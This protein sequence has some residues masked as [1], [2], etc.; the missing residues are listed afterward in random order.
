[1]RCEMPTNPTLTVASASNKTYALGLAVA[2][3][4][5][6]RHASRRYHLKFEVLDGGIPDNDWRKLCQSL[7]KLHPSVECIRLQPRMADFEGLPQDWGASVMTY[8][9][10]ALPELSQAERILYVDADMVIQEDVA[11]IWERPMPEGCVVAASRDIIT[12]TLA[13]AKLPLADFN[14]NPAHHYLQAGFLM[15]D[16]NAWKR[17]RVSQRV[18]DYL[19]KYPNNAMHWDQSALNVVLYGRWDLLPDEWNTPAW[20]ADSGRGGTRVDAPLL[21][22]VGPNKPWIL[23]HTTGESAKRFYEVVD[24]T[25]YRKWRPSTWRQSLKQAKYRLHQTLSL[26]WLTNLLPKMG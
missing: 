23:G 17:E 4:S 1:M 20:W 9:R 6:A 13:K 15:I 14:M 25:E 26:K 16:M 2:L 21:H 3:A 10:L 18:L 24:Q 22:Y 8:A 12:G 19:R 11:K 7:Q 5:V